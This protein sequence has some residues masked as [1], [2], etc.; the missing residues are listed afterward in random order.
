[1]AA[2]NTGNVN[3]KF[4]TT[5]RDVKMVPRSLIRDISPRYIE[6]E[7]NAIPIPSPMRN[8]PV[9]SKGRL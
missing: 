5:V 4:V 3:E 8:R 9:R 1:M 2:K 7:V 6:A